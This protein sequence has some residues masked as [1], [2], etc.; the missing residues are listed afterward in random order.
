MERIS[1]VSKWS[2]FSGATVEGGECQG[3]GGGDW[4][5]GRVLGEIPRQAADAA[6]SHGGNVTER[7]LAINKHYS[8]SRLSN[9]VDFSVVAMPFCGKHNTIDWK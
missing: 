3:G 8:F 5:P 9:V 2:R 1:T 4:L 6:D 7:A